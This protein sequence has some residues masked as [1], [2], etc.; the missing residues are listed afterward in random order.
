MNLAGKIIT[1]NN[2]TQSRSTYYLEEGNYVTGY[3]ATLVY[4]MSGLV[5]VVYVLE[6]FQKKKYEILS[7][8]CELASVPIFEVQSPIKGFKDVEVFAVVDKPQL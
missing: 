7:K 3:Y 1:E 6:T 5:R 4:V 8:N 2:R